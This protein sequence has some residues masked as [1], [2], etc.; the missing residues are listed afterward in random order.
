MD[1][2][3]CDCSLYPAG[4][5]LLQSS[6]AHGHGV[7]EMDAT[8]SRRLE[9]RVVG[10]SLSSLLIFFVLAFVLILY[11]IGIHIVPRHT[12]HEPCKQ[13]VFGILS[14][15]RTGIPF[16]HR[17]RGPVC[18]HKDEPRVGNEIFLPGIRGK[19]CGRSDLPLRSSYKRLFG[20]TLLRLTHQPHRR[21][22]GFIR[23]WTR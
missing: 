17:V 20:I 6:A 10:R 16:N 9:D 1:I 13:H 23:R 12:V 21:S 7:G 3:L 11:I 22:R 19:L 4:A 2:Y 14:L 18:G 5:G 8:P 15:I